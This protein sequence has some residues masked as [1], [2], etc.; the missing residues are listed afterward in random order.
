MNDNDIIIEYK[1]P[2]TMLPLEVVDDYIKEVSIGLRSNESIYG[3]D[4]FVA[5]RR[6]DK[7]IL[8]IENNTDQTYAIVEFEKDRRL[9]QLKCKVID[10]IK[11]RKELSAKLYADHINAMNNIVKNS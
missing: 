7:N 5:A 1:W 10:T 8:L 11:T 9:I 6:E 2:W 4:I 3:K